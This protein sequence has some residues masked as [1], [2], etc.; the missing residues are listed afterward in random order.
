MG[1]EWQHS[2]TRTDI[3]INTFMRTELA[4]YDVANITASYA[5]DKQLVL[6]ARV[7][8]LF[9][10]DYTLAHG[11]STLGRSVFVGLNYQH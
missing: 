1:V 4:G 11:Y 7:D 10:R 9:D 3:D 5:L 2:G 6:S 8:N